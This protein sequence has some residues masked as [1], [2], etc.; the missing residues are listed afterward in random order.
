M[1]VREVKVEELMHKE[2]ATALMT[3]GVSDAASIMKERNVGTVIVVDESRQIKGIITDRT[4]ALSVAEHKDLHKMNVS[5]IMSKN[6][7]TTN[8]NDD[9]ETALR[10]MKENN[11]RRLP[12]K[13]KG[14]LVGIVSVA[15]LAI[16]L[17]EELDELLDVEDSYAESRKFRYFGDL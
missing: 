4:I 8:S 9:I 6:V 13:D 14:K 5:D 2:P 17:K 12:V 15:D 7:I 1:E 11:V 3:T 10:I 16:E